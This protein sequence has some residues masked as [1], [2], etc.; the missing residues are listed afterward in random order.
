M[1][2]VASFRERILDFRFCCPESLYPHSMRDETGE[3]VLA[4]FV[5][6]CLTVWFSAKKVE[7]MRMGRS[8][9][10]VKDKCLF[11]CC[12]T[13]DQVAHVAAC[14]IE[15]TLSST[16]SLGKL[17]SMSSQP[18]T[19]ITLTKHTTSSYPSNRRTSN[20]TEF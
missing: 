13:D 4:L 1:T 17:F 16:S 14:G 7:M 12:K 3:T 19:L 18:I 9:D 8:S 20:C 15:V 5:A 10:E 11:I 6:L 2:S